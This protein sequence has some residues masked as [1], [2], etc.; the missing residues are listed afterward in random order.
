M[1]PELPMTRARVLVAFAMTEG[2]LK[3]SRV[4]KVTS[5]PPPATALIAPPAAA[6]RIKPTI[7]GPDIAAQRVTAAG[8]DSSSGSLPPKGLVITHNSQAEVREMA[9]G[10]RGRC[11]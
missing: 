3:K 11:P 5:V 2:V 8:L 10:P 7:S 9:R 1:L 6:A 4:G